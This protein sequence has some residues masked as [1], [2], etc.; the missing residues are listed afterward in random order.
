MKKLPVILSIMTIC[1]TSCDKDEG[2]DFFDGYYSYKISGDFTLEAVDTTGTDDTLNFILNS[3]SGQMN[4]LTR[5]ECNGTML[6]S[7]NETSGEAFTVEATASG[8]TLT[9]E[10]TRRY[11]S[12][13]AEGRTPDIISD[14]ASYTV[15]VIQSGTAEKLDDVV[16]FHLNF[17]G[18][19]ITHNDREYTITAS[20]IEGVAKDNDD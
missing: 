7:F 3:E 10:P 15:P 13:H 2:A 18:S 12:Y 5:D 4:I 20:S 16:I 1:L 11:I 17:D 8:R 14:V 6:V 9:L 19:T